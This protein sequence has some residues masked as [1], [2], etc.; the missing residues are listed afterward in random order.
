MH[1]YITASTV[2]AATGA[3]TTV[4]TGIQT[5]YNGA[6]WVCVTEVGAFSTTQATTASSSYVI[7]LTGDATAV[8]V[9]LSTGTTA[10]IDMS[11][12]AT[13]STTGNGYL[14][15]SVSGATTIAAN[16]VNMTA[17]GSNTNFVG[18]AR[19]AIITGLTA[20]TNTFTLN[21]RT[22]TGTETFYLRNLIVKGVA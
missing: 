17:G 16:D 3:T 6:A 22:N 8:S 15:Y 9:T 21:Y 10:R 2:A 20:G 1:A 19:N 11:F 18:S 4:P 7:T 5:I 13:S 12:L 14:T